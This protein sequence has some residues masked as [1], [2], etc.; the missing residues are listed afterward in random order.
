VKSRHLVDPDLLG[1]FDTLPTIDLTDKLLPAIRAAG[2]PLQFEPPAPEDAEVVRLKVS[3]PQGSPQVEVSVYLPCK[4]AEVLPCIFH[5]HGGGFVT[6]KAAALEPIHRTLSVA[7]ECCIVSVDY[8]LAP[9]TR[10][11]G[12]LEDCYAA[13]SW[14]FKEACAL[15][16]D[17]ARIGVMGESAGGGLAAALAL[18]TRDRR[19]YQLAFQHLIYPMLDDRTVVTKEPHPYAGEFLWTA[20]NNSFGWTSLLGAAPGSALVSA[21]AAPA[22]AED[23]SGLPPAFISTG[24]LDLFLEEDMEYARRLMRHGV[25]VELHVY[26]GAYHGFDFLTNAPVA[27]AARRD[28]LTALRRFLHSGVAPS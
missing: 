25:S 19:E 3:G 17:P 8:R 28:S 14:V 7:A 1:A 27:M 5:I 22:R 15:G 18:L 13:L 2:L 20:H 24:G 16:V 21:Y 12:S 11:P 6:G 9:E 23:L 4:R 26:A 10:F